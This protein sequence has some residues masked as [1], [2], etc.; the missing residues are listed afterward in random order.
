MSQW[1]DPGSQW[2]A[3]AQRLNELVVTTSQQADALR[4][5]ISRLTEERDALANGVLCWKP[6]SKFK[7][8]ENSRRV[9][10]LPVGHE[11]ARLLRTLP[12][13]YSYDL[14]D[15]EDTYFKASVCFSHFAE[16]P[17]D[18]LSPMA[19]MATKALSYRDAAQRKAGALWALKFLG[20]IE[21]GSDA[22][23]RLMFDIERGE[24]T[25]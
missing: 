19:E 4:A 2:Q 22:V 11:R 15:D 23:S 12:E 20:G 7:K 8:H 1:N 5:E 24:V 17:A 9:L 13:D 18:P 6:I 10:V 3:E 14:V 25:P 21:Y 16:L